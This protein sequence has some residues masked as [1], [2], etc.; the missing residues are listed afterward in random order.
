MRALKITVVVVTSLLLVGGAGYL[1]AANGIK[2]KLGYAKLVTP[3]GEDITALLSV[4]VGPSGVKPARWLL[5]QVADESGHEHQVPKRVLNSVLQELKGVQ[6]RV[7]DVGSNR[8]VFD[9][10]IADSVT[11]LKQKNW[12]TL[13]TVREGDVK[14]AVLQYVDGE[15]IA[16]LS[17]MAS[18]PDKAMFLN[19]IGPFNPEMI[20]ETA[21]Q[22]N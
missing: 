6:L 13:A 21:R 7:Y 14:V 4:N 8:H 10:A 3:K 16:G 12:Q 2:S 22:I 5:K 19:L 20:A 15:Q 1:Y 17:I 18:T 9:S 11:G